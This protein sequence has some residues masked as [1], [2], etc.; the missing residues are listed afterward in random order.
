MGGRWCFRRQQKLRG[1]R[2]NQVLLGLDGLRPARF[3]AGRLVIMGWFWSEHEVV[4]PGP[5]AQDLRR[6]V[7]GL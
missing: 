5:A 1:W 2:W 3:G 6:Q 4:A 7:M